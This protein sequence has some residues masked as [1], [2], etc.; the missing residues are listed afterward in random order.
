M[1]RIINLTPHTIIVKKTESEET[2]FEPCGKIAR[3]KE[4]VEMLPDEDNIPFVK[5]TWGEIQNLPEPK[6]GVYYLVSS[7]VFAATDRKDVIA[8]DTGPDSAIRDG[9]GNIKAV[10]RLKKH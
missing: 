8:A 5:T 7:I 10:K 1:K 6:N 9:N 2:A 4:E 3:V